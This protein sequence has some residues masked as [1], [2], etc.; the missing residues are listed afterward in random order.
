M[1]G[2]NQPVTRRVDVKSSPKLQSS[3]LKLAST[4][5]S[6]PKLMTFEVDRRSSGLRS[7]FMKGRMREKS[8]STV[9]VVIRLS[10]EKP[11]DT[12]IRPV[13]AIVAKTVDNKIVSVRELFGK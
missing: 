12:N 13:V 8:P 10:K 1:I 4:Q 5:M 2:D 7:A 11:A 6:N 3:L 9:H